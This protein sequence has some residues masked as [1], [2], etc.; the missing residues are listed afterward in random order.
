MED[1]ARVGALETR[2]A[3]ARDAAESAT[4][5]VWPVTHHPHQYFHHHVDQNPVRHTERALLISSARL[6]MCHWRLVHTPYLIG[7]P[8]SPAVLLVRR[9]GWTII[10]PEPDKTLDTS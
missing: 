1:Q 6:S 3:L 10:F 8:L 4:L 5:E 2:R 7:T 9:R